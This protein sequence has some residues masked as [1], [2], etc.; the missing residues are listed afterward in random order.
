LKSDKWSEL[1]NFVRKEAGVFSNKILNPET[2][3]EDD[4]DITGD[5]SDIF[6]ERFFSYFLVDVG[7][8]EID[9]YFSGEGGGL[10]SILAKAVLKKNNGK[11]DNIP[12]TLGMLEK[13]ID[14]KI[15]DTKRIENAR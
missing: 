3:L 13:A 15:W 14:L 6:M 7:D 8:F 12:L 9:R 1:E 4:L 10:L 5:D 2:S 11:S